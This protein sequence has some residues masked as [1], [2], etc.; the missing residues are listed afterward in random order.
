MEENKEIINEELKE[1]ENEVQG[2]EE[3]NVSENTEAAEENSE[4]SEANKL[5]EENKR[6]TWRFY[7]NLI[8]PNIYIYNLQLPSS[9]TCNLLLYKHTKQK[10]SFH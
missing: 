10:H 4:D 2:A 6:K 7:I 8:I 5:E 3:A 1:E 9:H